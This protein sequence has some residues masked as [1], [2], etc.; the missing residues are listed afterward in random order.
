M[1]ELMQRTP[2]EELISGLVGNIVYHSEEDGFTVLR[3]NARGHTKLVTL[4]GTCP[5]IS[6][7]QW[8][9]ASGKFVKDGNYGMQFRA[10]YI[11]VSEPKSLDGIEKY[12]AS[13]M[14]PGI[15]EVYAKRLVKHFGES[16]FEVIDN[17]PERLLEVE[18]IGQS[19]LEKIIEAWREQKKIR[20]IMVYLHRHEIP[21]AKAIRIYKAYGANAIKILDENPYRLARDMHGIG[22][23]GADKIAQSLGID[24][25]AMIRVGAGI[26]HVLTE[27]TKDGH[28]GLPEQEM[29]DAASKLLEVPMEFIREALEREIKSETLIN[30]SVHGTPCVFLSKLFHAERSI[31]Y[32]LRRIN[33]TPKRWPSIDVEKA[34]DWV[35]KKIGFSLSQSQA[36]AVSQAVHSKVI[37][38]TGGPG[39]GKTTIVDSI[40]R[41]VTAKKLNVLLCA[42]TGRAAKR[43]SEATGM[44]AKTIHRLLE[45][46]PKNGLFVRN[47][48]YP[49]KCD[50]LIVDE[51]SMIDTS[52][53]RSLLKAIPDHCGFLIIGD[54]DQLPSVGPGQVLADIIRSGY[55]RVCELTEVF[56]QMAESRIIIN[57]HRI[58]AGS[59]PEL[60]NHETDGDFYFIPVEDAS[61]AAERVITL[62]SRRIPQKFGFDPIRDIQVLCPM[63]NGPA[64]TRALNV[65]LQSVLNPSSV[66]KIERSGNTYSPG[67]KVMQIANDY[68]KEIFNGDIGIIERLTHRGKGLVV[69]FDGRLVPYEQKELD[70]LVPAYATTIHKSQGSEYPAVIL[71]LLKQHFMM[72]RRNLLYTGVTRGKQLVVLVGQKQAIEIALKNSSRFSRWSKLNELLQQSNR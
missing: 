37:V 69:N 25:T 72:L 64:G 15:G 56:R 19:R 44:E 42:P 39:V 28:C 21:T 40:V 20:E 47:E 33:T 60:E 4:V 57:A 53:M 17:E 34:I 50:L 51:C 43:M 13:G 62:A 31:A 63:N 9:D 1:P 3:L 49:L 35:E 46:D 67:D 68:D 16:V 36:D 45:F 29:L 71:L 2:G 7:G 22:F 65:D 55:L 59:M 23:M 10:S 18:G 14:I 6:S 32:H 54:I 8:I 5:D 70:L 38:I 66:E 26:A 30:V 24:K 52:L 61:Q 11:T 58:N 12:M 48:D 41:I 27:A